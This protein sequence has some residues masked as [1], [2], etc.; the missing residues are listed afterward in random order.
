MTPSLILSVYWI[1]VLCQENQTRQSICSLLLKTLKCDK[2]VRLKT[3]YEYRESTQFFNTVCVKASLWI[4]RLNPECFPRSSELSVV[5]LPPHN[6]CNI[7]PTD[8]S[9]KNHPHS[10]HCT[11]N[12]PTSLHSRNI[13]QRGR[14]TTSTATFHKGAWRPRE[15]LWDLPKVA[16]ALVGPRVKSEFLSPC[17]T[18]SGRRRKK[19]CASPTLALGLWAEGEWDIVIRQ[20]HV[21]S[22][23]GWEDLGDQ[24]PEYLGWWQELSAKVVTI[25]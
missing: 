21:G 25:S 4:I 5:A 17:L 18:S 16:P 15:R 7:Q 23:Y 1:Y 10:Q 2:R 20:W 24:R 14:R 13:H 12:Y 22:G 11:F 6:F 3:H 8:M 19:L 9:D